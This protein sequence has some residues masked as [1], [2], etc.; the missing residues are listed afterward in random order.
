[1]IIL[2]LSIV[3]SGLAFSIDIYNPDQFY[4]GRTIFVVIAGPAGPFMLNI[5]CPAGQFRGH[6]QTDFGTFNV[7]MT[8][9]S[10]PPP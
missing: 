5:C 9:T 8:L 4:S 10:D 1:M 6:L 7:I 3:S 2:S